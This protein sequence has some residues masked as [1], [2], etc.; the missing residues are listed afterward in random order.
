[1]SPSIPGEIAVVPSLL[2]RLLD[3]TPEVSREPP[4]LHLQSVRELK[5]SVARDLEA[6]LNTRQEAILD[7]TN[8]FQQAGRSLLNYGLPDLLACNFRDPQARS[9]ICRILE[10]TLEQF[11]PRLKQ[12]RVMLEAPHEHERALRFR[13]D[14]MLEVKPAREPIV[15]DA[16][17][18]LSTYEYKIEGK[19]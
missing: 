17:L 8:G 4:Q 3:D 18:Q 14:A 13:V 16:V 15:F 11:E 2:D 1:M 6:L 9:R 7:I 12:I 19:D 10:Q 5:N